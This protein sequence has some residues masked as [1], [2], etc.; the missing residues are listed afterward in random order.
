LFGV[1]ALAVIL[2]AANQ[3]ALNDGNLYEAV[4]AMQ[5]LIGR[6]RPWRRLYSV[7]LLGA[8]G[9][10]VAI[11]MSSLEKD[12][13]IV[14]GIS[15]VFVPCATTI[16]AVDYFVLPRLIKGRQRPVHR[17]TSWPKAATCNWL[18]LIAL[19]VGVAVGSYTGGLIPGLPGFGTASIG[20]PALQ[21][22]ATSACLYVV[23]AVIVPTA[24]REMLLGYPHTVGAQEELNT[25][26]GADRVVP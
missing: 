1:P 13:F 4:N 14:A 5:N 22:W 6:L 2:F 15:A 26:Q 21:A 17:I 12:F 8:L 7:L 9:V 11:S 3:F 18:G 19:G 20:Y 10:V 23:L 24:R 16:I 25:P